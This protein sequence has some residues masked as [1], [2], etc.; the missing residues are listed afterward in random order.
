[1]NIK[2]RKN[3]MNEW[4]IAKRQMNN[5]D[6]CVFY[7]EHLKCFSLLNKEELQATMRVWK[8]Q[9]QEGKLYVLEDNCLTKTV[10]GQE[11]HLMVLQG[12]SIN[13]ISSGGFIFDEGFVGVT[14]W[15]YMFK[16]KYTRDTVFKWLS[17]FCQV[18]LDI[19]DDQE[20]ENECEICMDAKTSNISKC[21]NKN[22]C[23]E[24]VH[25]KDTN[26]CP[27]CRKEY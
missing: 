24:C 15:I 12:G 9:C 16:S 14:G 13:C 22:I 18:K 25:K 8:A 2:N 7:V 23:R 1:M 10:D 4:N 27:F 26:S 19:K 21:C 3:I 6:L 17:K 5:D 20:V 11:Y